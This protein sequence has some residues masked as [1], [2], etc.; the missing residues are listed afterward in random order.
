LACHRPVEVAAAIVF[1]DLDDF[2]LKQMPADVHVTT[3][4]RL[5]K[6]LRSLPTR[7]DNDAVDDIFAK[8]RLSNTWR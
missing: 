7:M 1:V 3:G 5:I 8:A 6:W 4:R 2:T